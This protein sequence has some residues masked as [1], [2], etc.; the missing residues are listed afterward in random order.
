MFIARPSHGVS[1]HAL[2]QRLSHSPGHR[3]AG[4]GP[5]LSLRLEV[6][7]LP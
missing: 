2:V 6:L 3:A 7:T 4:L 1:V 5:E